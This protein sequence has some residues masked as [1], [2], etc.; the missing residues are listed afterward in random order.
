MSSEQM[1]ARDEAGVRVLAL[2]GELDVLSAPPLLAAIRAEL[3]HATAVVLDLTPVTFFDSSGVRLVDQVAR[4][5]ARRVLPLRVVAPKGGLTRR[6]LEL[7]GMTG[8]LVAD[9]VT[10]AIEAVRPRP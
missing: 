5:C 4:T 9:G 1:Q 8:E 10:Q 6:V 7:T 2:T 3:E